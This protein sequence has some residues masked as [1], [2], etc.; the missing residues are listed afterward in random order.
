MG[1]TQQSPRHRHPFR[2][3]GRKDPASPAEPRP[4]T[5]SLGCFGTRIR[6]WSALPQSVVHI[7]PPRNPFYRRQ[8][9]RMCRS[10]GVGAR[11]IR[12]VGPAVLNRVKLEYELNKE[13]RWRSEG[14]KWVWEEG[15]EEGGGICSEL[16]RREKVSGAGEKR[17]T[18]TPRLR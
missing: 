4:M 18:L 2:A 12:F 6:W 5:G 7:S 13:L 11:G 8:P 16:C 9:S 14:W 3:Q 1:L 15:C 10:S 17:F